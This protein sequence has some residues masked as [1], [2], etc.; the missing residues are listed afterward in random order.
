MSIY[1]N[2]I[3]YVKTVFNSQYDGIEFV[4]T[5]KNQVNKLNETQKIGSWS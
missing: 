5:K 2:S 4:C 3:S 1:Y